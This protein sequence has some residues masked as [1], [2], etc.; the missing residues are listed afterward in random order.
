[1]TAA[2][3]TVT[4]HSTVADVYAGDIAPTTGAAPP[5]GSVH[6]FKIQAEAGPG[7][8]ARI[9]NVLGIANVKRSW[10]STAI[11]SME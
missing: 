2:R 8:F 9:A 10:I 5:G 11:D 3:P 4:N 6:I 7:T 1:M